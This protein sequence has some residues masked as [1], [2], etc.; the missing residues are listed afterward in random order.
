[1]EKSRAAIN[2]KVD[3]GLF[4]PVLLLYLLGSLG[5]ALTGLILY[6]ARIGWGPMDTLEYYL[7]S[8]QA[9]SLDPSRIDRFMAPRTLTGLAETAVGHLFAYAFLI[10]VVAHLVRSLTREGPGPRL[11]KVLAAF[12]LI[13]LLELVAG[14]ALLGLGKLTEQSTMLI[15][16]AGIRLAIFWIFELCL[17]GLAAMLTLR[18]WSKTQ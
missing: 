1:M 3:H 8:E 6:V 11:E 17:I 18:L 13:A 7:G 12:F 5:S 4:R 14:P 10:F 9:L 2:G 15:A 16:G